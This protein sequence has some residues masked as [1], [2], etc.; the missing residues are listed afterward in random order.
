[1]KLTKEH[2]HM[3]I[4]EAVEQ[5]MQ[6]EPIDVETKFA[7]MLSGTLR[8]WMKNKTN[9]LEGRQLR[10]ARYAIE[11]SLNEVLNMLVRTQPDRAQQDIE[12]EAI[13]E[14]KG[15][16][17]FI[18]NEYVAEEHRELLDMAI[19]DGNS[20]IA[21]SELAYSMDLIEDQP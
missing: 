11:E 18:I 10:S 9:A 17:L 20:F 1:M 6:Q 7:Q 15:F 5:E 19:I 21:A 13:E 16:A 4:K 14:L 3:L 8:F 12:V 2:L